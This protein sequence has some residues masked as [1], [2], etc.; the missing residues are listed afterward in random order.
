MNCVV[1]K[2]FFVL[3]A[4]AWASLGCSSRSSEERSTT[5]LVETVDAGVDIEEAKIQADFGPGYA[6]KDVLHTFTTK[7]GE[8]VDCVD[9][10]AQ[11]SV[12]ALAA[13]G[14]P[15]TEL[16]TAPP[17]K[18][19]AHRR[20]SEN[21]TFHGEPDKSGSACPSGSV[22]IL[23]AAATGTHT[24]NGP[25][26]AMVVRPPVRPPLGPRPA[27]SSPPAPG[28]LAAYCT[29]PFGVDI[30]NYA[31]VQ[32]T[33]NPSNNGTL[34]PEPSTIISADSVFFLNSA[35]APVNAAN[36]DHSNGQVWLYSGWGF[37]APAFGCTC[38]N[39]LSQMS[40]TDPPCTQSIEAGWDVDPSTF[41]GT[42]PH[43][44]I[45][46]TNDGYATGCY[47][48]NPQL[49]VVRGG[50]C[51]PGFVLYPQ[52][53]MIL[54]QQLSLP[55]EL[56]IDIVLATQSSSPLAWWIYANGTAVGYYPASSFANYVGSLGSGSGAQT[57]QVGAEV[58]DATGTWVVPMGTGA[59]PLK[60]VSSAAYVDGVQANPAAGP[61]FAPTSLATTRATNYIYSTA[62]GAPQLG[63]PY[64]FYFGD[65]NALVPIYQLLR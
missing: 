33:F 19:R 40:V 4:V 57:F 30:A 25:D 53:T 15:I 48:N 20:T 62:P 47:D 38:T 14:E 16:P 5:S 6:A 56:S 22:P 63:A 2:R 13:R 32:Q 31:H 34:P 49:A 41:G 52:S 9:F 64:Y 21:V 39:I 50:S 17:L 27:G 37:S 42:A 60:G 24:S 59:S 55:L 65:G 28:P 54:G 51:V 12:K 36:Q 7:F 11:P 18:S 58:L 8:T 61:S 10:F 29:T 3:S 26:A 43:F 46:S 23:R 44:F 1:N 45:F 35:P